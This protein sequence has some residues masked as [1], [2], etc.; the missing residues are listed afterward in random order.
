MKR[1]LARE[2]LAAFPYD[3]SGG[4]GKRFM[5]FAPELEPHLI[6]LATHKNALLARN[7]V[8]ALGR[9]RTHSAATALAKIATDTKDHVILMR[10][11]A[12]L[13]SHA[14]FGGAGPVLERMRA[15]RDEVTR[16]ATAAALG[17]C[18]NRCGSSDLARLHPVKARPR[19]A[20]RGRHRTGPDPASSG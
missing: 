2:L 12:A 10:A 15:T 16:V 1:F 14:A 9:Y 6:E 5:L 19:P 3:P 8:A 4:F 11:L 7:A 17:R 13:G 18:G 20:S